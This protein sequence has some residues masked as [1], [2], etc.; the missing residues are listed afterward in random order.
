MRPEFGSPRASGVA[1]PGLI[2]LIGAA[3]VVLN[4]RPAARS[5]NDVIVAEK[6]VD[7]VETEH[8]IEVWCRCDVRTQPDGTDKGKTIW[9]AISHRKLMGGL[10]MGQT[11]VQCPP[12]KGSVGM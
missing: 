2:S 7:G 9:T 11:K 10:C 4:R 6:A 5:P 12:Y 1:L 8:I 3:L